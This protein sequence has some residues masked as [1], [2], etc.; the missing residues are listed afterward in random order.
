MYGLG[1]LVDFDEGRPDALLF[2]LLPMVRGSELDSVMGAEVFEGV[3]ILCRSGLGLYG[4]E[5]RR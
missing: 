5:A 4:R 1:I 3:V 2:L